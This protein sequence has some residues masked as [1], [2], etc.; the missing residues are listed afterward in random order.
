MPASRRTARPM[1]IRLIPVLESSNRSTR[2][3]DRAR[4]AGGSRRASRSHARARMRTR[5][6]R[7][8][9]RRR[10]TRRHR[11]PPERLGVRLYSF[12]TFRPPHDGRTANSTDR[13]SRLTGSARDARPVDSH[14]RPHRQVAGSDLRRR[15]WRPPNFA[16]PKR[17]SSPPTA[18]SPPPSCTSTPSAMAR[19]WSR[20]TARSSSAPASTP[21]ARRGTSSWSASHRAR[22]RS[23]GDRST[24]RSPSSTTI[25]CAR[26]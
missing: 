1:Y 16:P 18:T 5:R 4:C 17:R 20:R 6:A 23:G 22:P 13:G 7:A 3:A 8:G 11:T 21:G 26:G 9:G 25:A 2:R 14:S 12:A 10:R 19:G 15:P 24:S